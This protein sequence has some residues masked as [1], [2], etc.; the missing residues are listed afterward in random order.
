[1]KRSWLLQLKE[2][3][4]R[5]SKKPWACFETTGPDKD[6]RVGFSISYND[7]FIQNLSNLGMSGTTP[8]ET[9]QLFFLQMRMVPEN[10]MEAEQTVNPEAMPNL[11]SEAARFIR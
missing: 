3:I 9:V 1:M 6:G 2:L 11:S 10:M 4:A 8:E 5:R 7:A